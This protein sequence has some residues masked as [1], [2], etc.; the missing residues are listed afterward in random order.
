MGNGV[1][2]SYINGGKKT[3]AHEVY[4]W[5]GRARQTETKAMLLSASQQQHCNGALLAGEEQCLDVA[6]SPRDGGLKS[7]ANWCRCYCC[8]D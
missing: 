7:T 5:A 4:V 6:R 2:S 1:L 3:T 8:F